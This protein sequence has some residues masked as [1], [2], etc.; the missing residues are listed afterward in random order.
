MDP[1]TATA[2]ALI[3]PTHF[4]N[5]V[6]RSLLQEN[7]ALKLK[8]GHLEIKEQAIAELNNENDTLKTRTKECRR[9]SNKVDRLEE[10][11]AGVVA[12]AVWA[13]SCTLRRLLASDRSLI[14]ASIHASTH[15]SINQ[16]SY[17]TVPT[18]IA[19]I[20]V[21][22]QSYHSAQYGRI[23][24]IL[25]RCNNVL[26]VLLA[27]N[28]STADLFW[29]LAELPTLAHAGMLNTEN[30]EMKVELVKKEARIGELEA[31]VGRIG[32]A[33]E[34]RI[35]ELLQWKS[36][37]EQDTR[38]RAVELNRLKDTIEE[39]QADAT[40]R[41]RAETAGVQ[42]EEAGLQAEGSDRDSLAEFAKEIK[43]SLRDFEKSN[44]EVV[45]G[46]TN[47]TK[48]VG[49]LAGRLGLENV[50]LLMFLWF[51]NKVWDCTK[52]G[53][54]PRNLTLHSKTLRKQVVFVRLQMQG[55][56]GRPVRDEQVRISNA[57][58]VK[59]STRDKKWRW[60]VVGVALR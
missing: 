11:I 36:Q 52:L 47:A 27:S 37:Q 44:K 50:S 59:R 51:L 22:A 45:K 15:T 17:I 9:L 30:E 19:P 3:Q 58:R 38:E 60:Q 56:K 53:I 29:K 43:Q 13:V 42:A 41:T 24:L 39:L 55:S 25:I 54:R 34:A 7:N 6:I 46:F 33:L 12:W 5:A 8:I 35:S 21:V 2:Q 32:G 28:I 57:A 49:G 23:A 18:Y 26:G 1:E 20:Q 14:H 31:E 40:K 48:N 10:R 16:S 4:R